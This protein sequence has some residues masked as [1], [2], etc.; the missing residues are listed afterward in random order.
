MKR[1]FLQFLLLLALPAA[2]LAATTGSLKGTIS[3]TDTGAP[4]AGA[5]VII[6]GTTMG[7]A[8]DIDGEYFISNI[9]AGVYTLSVST[10]GYSTGEVTDLR[11][12]ADFETV[13]NVT[14]KESG[15]TVV[16]CIREV[17][18]GVEINAR[19]DGEPLQNEAMRQSARAAE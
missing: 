8:S 17:A 9:P 13:Q 1:G 3:S 7:A 18:G 14:L 12:H 15:T 16:C 19:D 10:V 11:I 4:L 2:L 6:K 5:N